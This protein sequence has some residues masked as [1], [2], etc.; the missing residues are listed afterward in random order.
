[1]M[2]SV[3][4]IF[5]V[6]TLM[7]LIFVAL[8]IRLKNKSHWFLF[9]SAFLCS[10]L[11]FIS[12]AWFTAIVSSIIFGFLTVALFFVKKRFEIRNERNFGETT[13]KNNF[14]K[15]LGNAFISSLVFILSLY[16]IISINFDL[17]A[18]EDEGFLERIGVWGD[19]CLTQKTVPFVI[20]P[21]IFLIFLSGIMAIQNRKGKV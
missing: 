6:I 20:I 3:K 14:K 4:A 8:S 17:P 21:S 7:I 10:I 12:G 15:L 18:V 19:Y 2:P 9:L 1:M 5:L 16:F 11:F 13:E